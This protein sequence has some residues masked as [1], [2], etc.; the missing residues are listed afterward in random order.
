MRSRRAARGRPPPV[1]RSPAAAGHRRPGRRRPPSTVTAA[2]VVAH[3]LPRFRRVSR[4]G[5]GRSSGPSS[6]RS[7]LSV[8]A[9]SLLM[10]WPPAR[11]VVGTGVAG[12]GRAPT[13]APRPLSRSAGRRH[14]RRGR[15]RCRGHPGRPVPPGHLVAHDVADAAHRPGRVPSRS[16]PRSPSGHSPGRRSTVA[17]PPRRGRRPDPVRPAVPSPRPGRGPGRGPG[18]RRPDDVPDRC[19]CPDRGRPGRRP[20]HARRPGRGRHPVRGRHRARP[21]GRRPGRHRTPNRPAARGGPGRTVAVPVG[22]R[23]P[24]RSPAPGSDVTALRRSSV[25]ARPASCDREIS[26]ASRYRWVIT[27]KSTDRSSARRSMSSAG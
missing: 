11:V 9:A 17:V 1:G 13:A 12:A 26:R 18:R 19:P 10:S 2:S 20:R 4:R 22:C 3:A 16:R 24:A 25:S 15:R 5:R 8:L 21:G 14:A 6:V 7:F 27:G 23:R